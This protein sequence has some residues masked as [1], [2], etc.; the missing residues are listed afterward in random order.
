M[1]FWGAWNGASY[2]PQLRF[3]NTV[4]IAETLLLVFPEKGANQTRAVVRATVTHCVVCFVL[5]SV[6]YVGG[7]YFVSRHSWSSWTL[8]QLFC[9]EISL[10]RAKAGLFALPSSFMD[11]SVWLCHFVFSLTPFPKRIIFIFQ[12]VYMIILRI[13]PLLPWNS[14]IKFSLCLYAVLSVGSVPLICANEDTWPPFFAP[15]CWDGPTHGGSGVAAVRMVCEG[16]R[17]LLLRDCCSLI[18]SWKLQ[19]LSS[20]WSSCKMHPGVR[21]LGCDST[22][23]QFGVLLQDFMQKHSIFKHQASLSYQQ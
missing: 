18:C 13:T 23:S 16:M 11:I 14:E 6:W 10:C 17:A 21:S 12:K 15:S 19:N 1:K 9:K 8:C 22:V 5:C 20:S 4:V 3:F 7:A 2:I